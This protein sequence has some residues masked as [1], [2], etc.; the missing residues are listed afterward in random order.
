MRER[1]EQDIIRQFGPVYGSKKKKEQ[2]QEIVTN[3]LDRY[4]EEL[5]NGASEEDAYRTTMASIGDLHALRKPLSSRS[6]DNVPV[7]AL[8]A[9]VAGI[10]CIALEGML[11]LPYS[12]FSP[13]SGLLFVVFLCCFFRRFHSC[14]FR[15][16]SRYRRDCE[17]Q[18]LEVHVPQGRR[19]FHDWHL[20]GRIPFC[21]SDSGNRFTLA[22]Y[23][24][25]G[26]MRERLEQ[27]IIR[28]FGPV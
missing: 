4:D 12:E 27:D 6:Q 13:F 1:L 3:A 18:S 23:G 16:D 20:S 9:L 24:G 17:E 22:Y 26:P 15:G 21:H 11:F 8:L 19:S 7:S 14:A 25:L 2:R 10:L 5:S 28:Q